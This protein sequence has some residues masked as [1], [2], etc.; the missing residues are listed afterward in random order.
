[1]VLHL[2]VIFINLTNDYPVMKDIYDLIEFEITKLDMKKKR[3]E[4]KY[5]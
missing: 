4:C 1:M 5:S 3:G 2:K